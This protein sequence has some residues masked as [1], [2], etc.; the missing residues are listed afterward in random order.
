MYI[1]EAAFRDFFLVTFPGTEIYYLTLFNI[2]GVE[3]WLLNATIFFL[4]LGLSALC[5]YFSRK[6]LTGW[7][8][9]IP[10]AIFLVIGF[11]L[12]GVDG[13]HRFF[14]VLA[15]LTAIALIFDKR[16][17]P[18]LFLAGIFCGIAASFTQPRGLVG[19][20]AIAV[21]LV[22]EKFY[23]KQ[24]FADLCKSVL[25]AAIP[26]GLVVAAILLYFIVT[27]GFEK[28]YFATFVFPVKYYPADDW[29]NFNAYLKSFPLIG[30]QSVFS[31]LKLLAP[32]LFFY[33]LIPAMYFIFAIVF[34]MKRQTIEPD[35][36]LQLILIALIGIFF[37]LGISSAPSVGRMYQVSIPALI[38]LIWVVQTLISRQQI[39]PIILFAL[40]FL[41]GLYSIQRQSVPVYNLET[42]TGTLAFLSTE[43]MVRFK[44]AAEN[45]QPFDY[46]Y[47]PHHPSLYSIFKLKN[48]TTMSWVRP[49]NYTTDEHI[50]EIIAGLEKNPPRYIIWNRLWNDPSFRNLPTFHLQPLIDYVEK[51]Y[52]PKEKFNDYN[53][54][55]DQVEYKIEIWE[56]NN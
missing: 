56:K 5:L 13:S 14:G 44:W 32:I 42:P 41:G 35:K 37:A 30:S 48:P 20:A 51:N 45:T 9:Y 16:T 17:F 15:V 11:R 12:L 54:F 21:F 53:N 24:S 49:N 27:A 38:L 3:Q 39:M 28:F 2:F 19:F 6:L 7:A 52:H 8:V 23:K 26:F 29:N 33:L 25:S 31:Y 1:G 18:R 34:R 47:E 10:V 50:A 22:I 46:F 43:T 40:L 36:K 55:Q 4:L